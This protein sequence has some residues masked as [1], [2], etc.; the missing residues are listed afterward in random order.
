M[1]CE[2]Y[3]SCRNMSLLAGIEEAIYL[4]ELVVFCLGV[5][6]PI[7][8]IVDN[9]SLMQSIQSTHLVYE[10]RLRIDASA[11]KEFV[12]CVSPLGAWTAAAGWLPDKAWGITICAARGDIRGEIAAH[13][14]KQAMRTNNERV[15]WFGFI[16]KKHSKRQERTEPYT[17]YQYK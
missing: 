4:R 13:W 11:V 2:K 1:H 9:R 14:L 5:K 17:M 15:Y 7:M 3:I 16:I 10:K 12:Q 8:A 6:I